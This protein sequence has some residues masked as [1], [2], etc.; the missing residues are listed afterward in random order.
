MIKNPDK[1]SENP[2]KAFSFSDI[3]AGR[4]IP[5]HSFW[6]DL[7]EKKEINLTDFGIYQVLFNESFYVNS[8]LIEFKMSN[9][10][11]RLRTG[12]SQKPI[13]KALS[14]LQGLGLIKCIIGKNGQPTM[15]R[16]KLDALRKLNK[17]H[18][19]QNDLGTSGEMTEVDKNLSQ[20]DLGTSV[21]MT[22][23][24]YTKVLKVSLSHENKFFDQNRRKKLRKDIFRIAKEGTDIDAIASFLESCD[25][26]RVNSFY[27]IWNSEKESFLELYEKEKSEN[28]IADRDLSYYPE[29]PN[30][31]EVKFESP[32]LIDDQGYFKTAFKGESSDDSM[33]RSIAYTDLVSDIKR[34][35]S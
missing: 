32:S 10:D 13:D 11:I 3:N 22:D 6:F 18:L 34:Y 7:L 27:A 20:K 15:I 29:T 1:I 9:R 8:G 17:K 30:L 16:I 24:L 35:L 26:E 33:M 12:L 4:H 19:S 28:E 14:K 31:S 2:D 23:H 21:K 5:L 25:F